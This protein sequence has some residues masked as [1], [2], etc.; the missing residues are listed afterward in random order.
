MKLPMFESNPNM[1]KT[2]AVLAMFLVIFSVCADL[3]AQSSITNMA[4]TAAPT[5]AKRPPPV[6]RISNLAKVMEWVGVAVSDPDYYVWCTSPIEG[7]DGR[8]HLFVSRWPKIYKMDGWRT[9]CEIAH[10]VGDQP[11]GP[12]KFHDV[13]LPANPAALWNNTKHNPCIRQVGD[14]YCLLY[15]T[16]D[17]RPSDLLAA[18]KTPNWIGMAI[19]DSLAGPWKNLSEKEPLFLP[20]QNT[21][22]WSFGDWQFTNPT[23]LAYG[24]K[25]YLYFHG[26]KHVVK[27]KSYAYAYADQPEGPYTLGENLCTDNIAKIEDATAFVWKDK[28]C[29]LTDDNYGTHTG[30]PGAGLLWISDRPDRFKLSDAEIGFLYSTNYTKQ[31]DL[32]KVRKLYGRDF[33]FERPGILMLQGKPAYFYGASGFNLNG[34]ETPESYVMK[35]NL[36]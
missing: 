22:H 3:R 30:I 18:G 27:M 35:I 24:G 14:K 29:L 4:T 28:I 10:Y 1:N 25:Y 2:Y 12:F 33:K 20:S 32:S 7:P 34:G 8:T 15:M 6:T 23:L 5:V 16:F 19:S 26:G 17:R 31:V 36:K 13:A 11:E 9:H 21:N